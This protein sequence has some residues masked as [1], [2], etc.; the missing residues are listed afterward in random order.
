MFVMLVFSLTE[1][2]EFTEDSAKKRDVYVFMRYFSHCLMENIK[3][4]PGSKMNGDIARHPATTWFPT[5]L[6][7]A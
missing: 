1:I 7:D 5:R 4:D 6:E 2:A 3:C